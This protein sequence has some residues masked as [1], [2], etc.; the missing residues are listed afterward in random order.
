[1]HEVIRKV[2]IT[3]GRQTIARPF[4]AVIDD[5]HSVIEQQE[6][7][8]LRYAIYMHSLRMCQNSRVSNLHFLMLIWNEFLHEQTG[9]SNSRLELMNLCLQRNTYQSKDRSMGSLDMYALNNW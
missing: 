8:G 1:M 4:P 7:V 6:R 3:A 5:R 2:T 9:K